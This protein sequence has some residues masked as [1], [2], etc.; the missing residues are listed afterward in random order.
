MANAICDVSA[1][2]PLILREPGG[3][4]HWVKRQDICVASNCRA[5][6]IG[7][8][9]DMAHVRA[10]RI[11]RRYRLRLIPLQIERPQPCAKECRMKRSL[12]LTLASQGLVA[13]LLGL[14]F[15]AWADR[16]HAVPYGH[17]HTLHALPDGH[18]AFDHGG[19][20]YY[21]ANGFWYRPHRSRYIAIA[22]PIGLRVSFL[23]WGFRTVLAGGATFFVLNDIWYQHIG[24]DYIVVVPPANAPPVP[25][26]PVLP[27]SEG[28]EVYL[29]PSNGQSESQQADD[30]YQCHKWAVQQT[31]FDPTTSTAEQSADVS[32]KPRTNYLRAFSA[33]LAGRGYVVN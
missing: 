16:G 20:R 30:R 17:G 1:T 32:G 3:L 24:A 19:H 2:Y 9:T 11:G 8:M 21:F 15:S 5:Q 14:S 7:S 22:P 28:T 23:P 33:C 27:S 18:R 10:A 13:L 29:Y 12:L 25:A 4:P 31:G 6:K 26:A